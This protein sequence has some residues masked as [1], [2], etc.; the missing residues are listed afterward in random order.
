MVPVAP[1]GFRLAAVAEVL[2]GAALVGRDI[3]YRWPV[4]GWVLGK[5]FRVSRAAG[6]AHGIRYARGRPSAC[7]VGVWGRPSAAASLLDAP[8]HAAPGLLGGGCCS[9]WPSFHG[10]TVM[11][12]GP[13]RL[14]RA[15]SETMSIDPHPSLVLKQLNWTAGFFPE[16][17]V[18]VRSLG[19][20]AEY[21]C[22]LLEYETAS[23]DT[24]PLPVRDIKTASRVTSTSA[25]PLRCRAPPS[26]HSRLPRPKRAV[27]PVAPRRRASARSSHGPQT[28]LGPA[29][30]GAPRSMRPAMR[31]RRWRSGSVGPPDPGRGCP[32]LV[33]PVLLTDIGACMSRHELTMGRRDLLSLRPVP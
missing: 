12:R 1:A 5:A 29:A 23:C 30:G 8:S 18:V 13:A 19:P 28:Q 2:A 25:C 24:G 6:F 17:A 15:C 3:L 27:Q 31:S 9:A 22:A 20:T 7:G 11:G 4:Q 16:P 14:C 26:D 21:R 32:E 33:K 10:T